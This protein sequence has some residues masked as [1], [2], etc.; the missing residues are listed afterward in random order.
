MFV[1]VWERGRWDITQFAHDF[2]DIDLHE[3]QQRWVNTAPWADERFLASGNRWGKSLLSGVKSLHHCLYQTRLPKYA[4]MTSRYIAVNLSITMD[5]SLVVWDWAFIRALDSPLY[6]RFV[7]ED[8]CR[9]TPFPIMIVGSGGKGKDVWRSEFWA[10]STVKKGRY[11]LGKDFDFVNYDEA[12][13]DPDG[14]IVRDDV[15]IMR[16]A[17]RNGR[18]DYTSTGNFR[19]WYYQ[20]FVQAKQAWEAREDKSGAIQYA[21]TGSSY[22]NPYIDHDKLKR[23][24]ERLPE[25]FRDQNIYGGFASSSIIFSLDD[26]QKCYAGQDYRLPAKPTKA[27]EY[28]G[29]IDWGRKED[30][31]V[32]LVT[33]INRKPAKLVYA[34]SM[35][36]SGTTWEDI[37][38]EV[39]AV[40]EDYNHPFLLIDS[41]GQQGDIHLQTLRNTYGIQKVEGYNFAGTK[42]RKQDLITTGQRALQGRWFR[43]PYIAELYDQLAFYD[44]NDKNLKTDWVMA[45]CLMSMAYVRETWIDDVVQDTPVVREATRNTPGAVVSDAGPWERLEANVYAV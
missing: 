23:N 43:W 12:A 37:Y 15:L 20:E 32:I 38:R 22:E 9:R 39:S 1:E 40:Y 14:P 16:M 30:E 5:M 31:T 11:L 8:E 21:Q 35:G 17:D 26:I 42:S 2:L 29:A 36:G 3:G 10:R 18:I 33:R 6:R 45:F 13:R 24:E 4:E 7:R 44:Y 41:T 28:I 25:E 34:K 27:G 19:N